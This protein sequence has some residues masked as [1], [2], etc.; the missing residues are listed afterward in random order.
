MRKLAAY[1]LIFTL[2]FGACLLL[3]RA[4]GTLGTV[5][6]AE[7]KRRAQEYDV[8]LSEHPAVP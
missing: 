8:H 3:L 5:S 2:G 1:G 4:Y 6:D 7:A